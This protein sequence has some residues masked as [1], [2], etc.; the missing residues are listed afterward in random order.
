M[1]GG[2][3]GLFGERGVRGMNQGFGRGKYSPVSKRVY[4]RPNLTAIV[5]DSV[6]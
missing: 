2:D 6:H 3:R 4:A 1:T 5:I